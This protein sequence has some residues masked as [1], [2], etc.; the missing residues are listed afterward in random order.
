[1]NLFENVEC[2]DFLYVWKMTRKRAQWVQKELD[3]VFQCDTF[4]AYFS[5]RLHIYIYMGK[6]LNKLWMNA[7][8]LKFYIHVR[9]SLHSFEFSVCIFDIYIYSYRVIDQT[10][11]YSL[12]YGAFIKSL[13][14][15]RNKQLRLKQAT[16]YKLK[17]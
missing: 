8:K 14:S 15:L 1:M 13:S 7:L 5:N 2:L 4:Y 16:I 6:Q 12:F 3:S 9:F 11:F 10:F 17:R